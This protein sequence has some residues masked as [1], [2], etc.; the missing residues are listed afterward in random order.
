LAA[1]RAV[2][3]PKDLAMDAKQR[4]SIDRVAAEGRLVTWPDDARLAELV[5]PPIVLGEG[6][7]QLA[8]VPRAIPGDAKAPVAVHVLNLRYDGETD[9]MIPRSDL[10]VGLRRDLFPGRQL[11]RA[12]LHAP[13]KDPQ[14]LSIAS[15]G[16][17]IRIGVPQLDLWAI[18]ELGGD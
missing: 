3:A 9:A 2:V 15:D 1:F 4:A 5:P 8:V 10:S 16:D 6:S 13:G 11:T 7:G 14:P 12:T 18:L 17:L